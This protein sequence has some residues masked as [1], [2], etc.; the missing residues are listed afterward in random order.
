MIIN[1]YTIKN[2]APG[3]TLRDDKVKGLQVRGF[4]NSSSYYF[5]YRTREGRERR[6]KIGS[7][8]VLTLADARTAARKL[9]K[10]V[11]LG[12]DPSKATQEA[13]QAPRVQELCG[14]YMTRH[15]ATKK[16]GYGDQ[17][18]IYDKI[19]PQIG[20]L[21]VAEVKHKHVSELHQSLS[22]TPY[23]ANRVIA[24]LSK[25]FSL[26][27]L[28]ELRPPYTNP[29]RHVKH[30]REFKRRRIMTTEET[31][32]IAAGLKKYRDRYPRQVLFL[33]LLILTG[34]RK[35]EIARAKPSNIQGNYLIDLDNKTGDDRPIYLPNVVLQ[36]IHGINIADRKSSTS[37]LTGIKDPKQV[38]NLIRTEAG[39][40]DLRLHDLRRTYAS[41]MISLGYSLD[42][43]G[44][45]LRH[46]STQTTARYAWLTEE[47]RNEVAEHV[48]DMLSDM[49]N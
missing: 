30:F 11:A 41:V 39:C 46:R 38:W 15:A 9:A 21:Y 27:E 8:D 48:A 31:K 47:T 42:Q 36:L 49:L 18:M 26:A 12:Q 37:T 13:R 45:L 14:M 32:L 35:S 7:T 10:S 43:I 6:P 40:K 25:M 3:G 5:Y 33:Y 44:E 24:L 22:D 17:R 1:A 4:E 28:W 19:L 20:Y 2:L 34:A 23:Q 16:T 29:C